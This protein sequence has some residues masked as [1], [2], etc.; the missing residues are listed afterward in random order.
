MLT[1]APDGGA[2]VGFDEVDTVVDT[3]QGK[4]WPV[5]LVG[6]YHPYCRLLPKVANCRS[7]SIQNMQGLTFFLDALHTLTLSQSRRV[8]PLFG[9]EWRRDELIWG[10]QMAYI[11][12]RQLEDL[13]RDFRPGSAGL[14]F[15]HFNV[16]HFPRNRYGE[17]LFREKGRQ[18][19]G[20]DAYQFNLRLADHVLGEILERIEQSPQPRVL[21]VVSGDH[22]RRP[23]DWRK[24]DSRDRDETL[25]RVPF[26]AWIKGE[27]AA[28]RVEDQIE[29]IGTRALVESYLGGDINTHEGIR[30]FLLA[31]LRP[32]PGQARA[33]P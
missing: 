24:G 21:V 16:P 20:D 5:Q 15:F 22:G 1:V 25:R 11:T 8:L 12:R 28:I 30:R 32:M 7:Y 14:H 23:L 17:Q 19:V 6:Y 18:S 2:H 27:R 33:Q 13:T 3:L 31:R 29:T 26:L 9:L 4:G 10:E